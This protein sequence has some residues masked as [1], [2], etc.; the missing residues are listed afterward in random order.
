MKK[1]IKIV[2]C[3]F[4]LFHLFLAACSNEASTVIPDPEVHENPL[5]Q[6]GTI[7][8]QI[9][10]VYPGGLQTLDTPESAVTGISSTNPGIVIVF[11]HEVENDGGELSSSIELL[12]NGTNVD[13]NIS[14]ASSSNRFSIEPS[15]SLNQ[16]TNYRI[17]VSKTVYVDDESERLL[18]FENIA[19]LNPDDP[20]YVEYEFQT[21]SST[22]SDTTAPTISS[23]TPANLATGIQVDLPNGYVEVVFNDDSTPMINPTT[24]NNTTMKL[25]NSVPAEISGDVQ[26]DTSNSNLSVYQF[27]PDDQLDYSTTYTLNISIGGGISDLSGN[28][29]SATSISFTTANENAPVIDSY[30]IE[31]ITATTAVISWST[32][33]PSIEHLDIE[34]GAT[35]GGPSYSTPPDSHNNGSTAYSF[36]HTAT[37]LTSNTEYSIRISADIDQGKGSAA[38]FD[39]N[40]TVNAAFRTLPG[41]TEGIT[42]NY[43]LAESATEKSGLNI[44][45]ISQD[46]SFIIW[47]DVDNSD[48]MGQYMDTSAGTP[49]TW[50]QWTNNAGDQIFTS[51]GN[52]E[53]IDGS[54]NRVLISRE[55]AGT[56]YGAA[57]YDNTGLSYDWGSGG[58]GV[59]VYNG[60]TASNVKMNI[61]YSGYVT[62]LT[63]ATG[64]QSDMEYIYNSATPFASVGAGDHVITEDALLMYHGTVVNK[65][66]NNFI[67][68][69]DFVISSGSLNYRIGDDIDIDGDA[70][71]AN[72]TSDSVGLTIWGDY[73]SL[74]LGDIIGNGTNYVSLT[75]GA[76]PAVGLVGNPD[77][78]PINAYQYSTN[79]ASGFSNNDAIVSYDYITD[80]AGET[81]VIY[82]SGKDLSSVNVNDIVVNTSSGEGRKVAD[83][84]YGVNGLLIF[85]GTIFL[86]DNTDYEIL[87]LPDHT[88]FVASG[89]VS[90]VSSN[91][92]THSAGGLTAGN[93]VYNIS[94][95]EYAEVT[96]VIDA[97]NVVLSSQICSVGHCFIVF[98]CNSISFVWNRNDGANDN[99]YGKTIDKSDGSILYPDAGNAGTCFTVVDSSSNVDC[100]KPH[101]VADLKGNS[102]VVYEIYNGSDWD[103]RAKK[104]SGDGSLL[105]A[106]PA[107]DITDDGYAIATN[108]RDDL[109]IKVIDDGNGGAWVLY[110]SHDS[111]SRVY[112]D[113]MASNGTVNQFVITS[114]KKPDIVR[115]SSSV[116][117]VVYEYYDTVGSDCVMR[118]YLRR[119][120][121]SPASVGSAVHV[122][123]SSE[124]Y[125]QLNPEIISDGSGGCIVS[126]L[127]T[128]YYPSVYY[129]LFAEHFDSSVSTRYYGDD[130]LVSIPVKYDQIQGNDPYGINHVIIR[131]DDGTAG[132][133][134][135]GVFFWTDERSSTQ[136][137]PDNIDIYFQNVTDNND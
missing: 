4:F 105:W 112:A 61:G 1:S 96:S 42:G 113:H 36:S 12:N 132:G 121:N 126:W 117:A 63:S 125:S 78:V 124:G 26:L 5:N 110:T 116:I 69:S 108:A 137:P 68:L 129:S 123:S 14:P 11:T 107:D 72:E 24:V 65:V 77:G 34:A 101:I 50:D 93:I 62:N 86:S 46:E 49:D 39:T 32:D 89:K 81:N 64:D 59:T 8:P 7:Y 88:N 19:D 57:I 10:M 134:D 106:D 99:I 103:I 27:F 25:Y 98:T 17:R 66:D 55:D 114:A 135:G 102:I 47:R 54:N 131:W 115:I 83:T 119:F 41:T 109:I 90:A 74:D 122:R 31:S 16:Y 75:T 58:T 15:S 79:K 120:D 37:G 45:Q 118:I 56:I 2:I 92:I 73:N 44:V 133:H 51:A 30:K 85:T 53:V 21:S 87:R 60:G 128:K 28:S 38:T 130:T 71:T 94:T 67:E 100:R 80:G 136:Y 9:L 95:G 84:T 40:T 111:I 76:P 70:D 23:T 22:T 20:E 3:C 35:F 127:E 82:D 6:S 13:I 97:S 104:I 43:K 33:R 48:I 29:F 18:L 52:I 91:Q